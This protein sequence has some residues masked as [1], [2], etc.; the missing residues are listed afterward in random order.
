MQASHL[1]RSQREQTSVV[2]VDSACEV[3]SR[4]YEVEWTDSRA[5]LHATLFKLD[6]VE[7]VTLKVDLQLGFPE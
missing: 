7:R 5:L 2:P 1:T 3:A 6:R 4:D